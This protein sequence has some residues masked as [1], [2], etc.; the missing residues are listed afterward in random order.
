MNS[1][2]L[3]PKNNDK[4][5]TKKFG[6]FVLR[7]LP[8]K[9]TE[10]KFIFDCIGGD[11]D[12]GFRIYNAI[13][14]NGKVDLDIKRAYSMGAVIIQ[15]ARE[16]SIRWNGKIMIHEPNVQITGLTLTEAKRY[17]REVER[18]YQRMCEIL[19]SRSNRSTRYWKSLREDTYFSP[20]ESLRLGLVDSIS[21]YI[22][23]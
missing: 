21:R 11:I 7:K 12:V 4:E 23:A 16:R 22:E 13:R 19:A 3:V 5:I 10:T 9:E 20:A 1:L 2:R 18:D 15:G 6:D 8:K 14:K 17:L